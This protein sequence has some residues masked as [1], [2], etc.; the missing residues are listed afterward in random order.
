MRETIDSDTPPRCNFDPRAH[1]PDSLS[2]PAELVSDA[3]V[4][5]PPPRRLSS[6]LAR[7]PCEP[8]S[9]GDVPSSLRR[10]SPIDSAE[11]RSVDDRLPAGEA[12]LDL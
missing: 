9:P 10:P 11:A 2:P 12:S 8:P 7:R 6:A 4:L 5:V 3:V 1:V